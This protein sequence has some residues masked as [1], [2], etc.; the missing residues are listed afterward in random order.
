M[1]ILVHMSETEESTI[2]SLCT[3]KTFAE[4]IEVSEKQVRRFAKSG[5]I[6]VVWI[7]ERSPRIPLSDGIKALR[8]MEV[9]L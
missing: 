7:G 5:V 6:P 2:P 9:S 1:T 3:Y 4:Q 8:K